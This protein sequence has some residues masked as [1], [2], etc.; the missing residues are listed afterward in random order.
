MQQRREKNKS[1]QT[2]PLQR[3]PTIPLVDQ[4]PHLE[5]LSSPHVPGSKRTIRIS[6]IKIIRKHA[7][8]PSA[9]GR[10][11]AHHHAI[12]GVV[13]AVFVEVVVELGVGEGEVGGM[14]MVGVRGR[15]RGAGGGGGGD[16]G[17][18]RL[19]VRED[20]G[21]VVFVF[22]FCFFCY[23]CYFLLMGLLGFLDLVSG[24]GLGMRRRR[25]RERERKKLGV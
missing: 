25:R 5:L 6:I 3:L 7:P 22:F 4:P 10:I 13:V 21:E 18:A 15:G 11:T 17:D 23:F 20:V 16:L 2:Q 8:S 14:G 19:V 24:D 1:S 12:V 9:D